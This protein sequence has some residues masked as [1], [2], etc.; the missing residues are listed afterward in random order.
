[1]DYDNDMS[2]ID[3]PALPKQP[4]RKAARSHLTSEQ[5]GQLVLLV[6]D[7]ET[8]FA[9]L[10]PEEQAAYAKSVQ[11]IIDAK[12]YAQQIAREIYIY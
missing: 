10:P 11:S 1:M 5:I 9:A 2:E 4:E 6:A 8:A 7:P 12:R 3:F